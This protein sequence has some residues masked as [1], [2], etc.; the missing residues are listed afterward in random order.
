MIRYEN[1]FSALR[2]G[3]VGGTY[4]VRH[5]IPS[6]RTLMQ[7]YGVS[8]NAARHAVDELEKAGLVRRCH[9][10][11]TQVV[12]GGR[13][14]RIG[15]IPCVAESEFFMPLAARLSQLCVD[16]G[17]AL[18]FAMMGPRSVVN[19]DVRDYE[20]KLLSTARDFVEQKISGVL[21][22]PVSFLSNA[23]ELNL[24]VLSIFRE[25]GI[26]VVLLDYD[27]TL[28]PERGACDVVGIDNIDAAVRLCEH[29]AGRGARNIHFFMR[30]RCSNVVTMRM[31]GVALGTML[32]G[33]K[34]GTE[35]V[36]RCELDDER[37]IRRH[38]RG[39]NRP[40]AIVCGFDTMALYL[41]NVADR[42]KLKVPDDL[43]IA[44]FDDRESAAFMV[45]SL[46]TIHQP[47]E[48]IAE[49]AFGRLLRRI[50]GEKLPPSEIFLPA[51]LMARGSTGAGTDLQSRQ[52]VCKRIRK[53]SAK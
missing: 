10:R 39:K 38:L 18:M 35:S 5:P 49:A 24:K 50:G 28:G 48:E 42:M 25:A 12:Y 17:Y 51:P 45:P 8:R 7:K 21:F 6:E 22:Q 15:L 2:D 36:L 52:Q 20:A 19:V 41:K 47:S 11:R 26:P 44:G 27:V 53:E 9:G 31:R 16:N 23:E 32:S 30:P 33:L 29:L 13:G 34:W 43:M 3:I 1:I 37:A 46:T 4:D 14:R 40:D